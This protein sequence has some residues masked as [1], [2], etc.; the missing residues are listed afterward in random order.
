MY[1]CMYND[2]EKKS[3]V[4]RNTSLIVVVPDRSNF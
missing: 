1:M 3:Q 2:N 4:G